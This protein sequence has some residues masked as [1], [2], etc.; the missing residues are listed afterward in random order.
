MGTTRLGKNSEQFQE[1][2]TRNEALEKSL[3]KNQKEK[4]KLK[5]RVTELERSLGQYRN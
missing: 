5:D 3:S 4:G 1:V 2:Q